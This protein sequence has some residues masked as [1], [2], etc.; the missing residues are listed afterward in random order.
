MMDKKD[1][2]KERVVYYKQPEKV[3]VQETTY[4]KENIKSYENNEDLEMDR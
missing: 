4:K 3:K 1:K 2:E